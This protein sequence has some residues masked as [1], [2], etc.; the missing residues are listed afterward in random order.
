MAS[1]TQ[2]AIDRWFADA[3]DRDTGLTMTAIAR[4]LGLS[5]SWISRLIAR[6]EAKGK[7]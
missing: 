1:L 4:R 7:T 3:P 5:V 6:E 2:G